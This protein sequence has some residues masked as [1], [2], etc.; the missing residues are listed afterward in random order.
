MQ[1]EYS[2]VV[3]QLGDK[4]RS[5]CSILFYARKNRQTKN[6]NLPPR[7]NRGFANVHET[8]IYTKLWNLGQVLYKYLS[9]VNADSRFDDLHL[10]LLFIVS[11]LSKLLLL[12]E[13]Y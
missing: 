12:Y 5:F 8:S 4:Y 1:L 2:T 6:E 13:N 10:G 3:N 7:V 11:S 9:S